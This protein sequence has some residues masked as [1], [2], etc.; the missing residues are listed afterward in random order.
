MHLT[1]HLTVRC[2]Y[3]CGYC[4]AAPHEGGDMTFDTAR[5][6]IDMVQ[7][8][9]EES[10]G[11]IFFGGEPLLMRGLITDVVRYC[12]DLSGR[13]GRFFHF[14]V[15]TNGSLLDEAFLTGED[16]SDIFVALSHDGVKAAHDAHRLDAGGAGTFD[17]L[18]SVI[19]LLLKH[20]PYSP[21]MLVVNPDTVM[22]YADSVSYLFDRGFKYLICSLNY[23]AEW[24]ERDLRELRRQYRTLAD[25]YFEL[26][27]REEKFYF[28]S[29]EV[30]I[31][32]H[33]FP[34]SCRAER[35]ELGKT[36]ISVGPDGRLY[37]CVQFV[38]DAVYSIGD[39][40]TGI[41]EAARKRL[42]EINAGEKDSCGDCAVRDRC[43]HYCGC[44]NRQATGS[45]RMVSPVLCAHERIVLPIA[46][47]LAARLYKRRSGMFIQKHYNEMFPLLSLAEDR[48]VVRT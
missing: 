34:G 3:R 5:K 2:N 39:V 43:N 28:S 18:E 13:T 14:K 23:G 46:D 1:L 19:D 35:C 25:W 22:H 48:T 20:K 30:K 42:Y 26:T 29:F 32:S 12:R 24:N 6:A 41:D 38:G 47:K 11:V 16:T 45:I 27:M 17:R 8:S 33:V 44:L 9:G 31:S 36:Q 37:P 10:L 15:T 21:V 40:R 4:Y 7:G